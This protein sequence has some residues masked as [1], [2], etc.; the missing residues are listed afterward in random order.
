[1]KKYDSQL[2]ELVEKRELA[3]GIFDFMLKNGDIAKI[4]EPGQFVHI[5]IP[6]MVLR[7]PISVCDVKDGCIRIVFRIKGDGTR[8]LSQAGVGDKLD[9]L[10]P[11][12]SGF[13]IEKGKA[14]AFVGGGIGVPPMLYSAK[15]AD[16]AYAV[17]GFANKDAVILDDD[18]KAAGCETVVTTDDGSFGLRGFVTDALKNVIDKIDGVCACGPE[19]ML[20]AVVALC[21]EHG[22]PCQV[23]LEER[24]GCGIGACLVCAC[25]TKNKDGA[26]EYTHVC[27]RGPVFNAEEVVWNG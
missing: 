23:S 24:M 13:N 15:R 5:A 3:P 21:G 25:K 20:K 9:L 2:F 18:F 1:M 11:L 7:R 12:G 16:K 17:L 10:A 22:K 19:P 14:Y 6:G 27:K 26:E 4:T 8:T